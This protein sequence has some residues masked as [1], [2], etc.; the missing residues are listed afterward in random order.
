MNQARMG[1]L[2]AAALLAM[3][4]TA[5]AQ[6][7]G[8]AKAQ[9]GKKKDPG[10]AGGKDDKPKEVNLDEPA[11]DV[12][13]EGTEGPQGPDATPGG[14]GEGL[15]DICKI[16][17]TAC[18][19]IDMDKAAAREMKIDMYA[20]Q[21]IY[22]LR[23]HRFE[24]NPYFGLTM[25]DQFVGHNGPG[26]ALN[27]YITNTMAIGVNGN[28]YAGLN[29]NSAFNFET[30]RAGR[31]GEPVTEYQWNANANFTYVPAY[32][33]FAGFGDFIF[34][35]DIFVI[36]GVGAI[37][38]RPIAVVDP[39]NRS[40]SFKPKFNGRLGG[41]LRIFF[42]RWLS[43]VFEVS[44]YLFLDEL[45]NP[46]IA[47]GINAKTGKPKAQDQTTWLDPAGASFTNNVQAQVGLSI[48]L[49]FTWEYRLPK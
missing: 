27:W 44:D 25:N 46:K 3:P 16:D 13:K 11:A 10:K 34:H 32:G 33:K 17:P 41:G 5:M 40:F 9:A 42:N 14:E 2:V 19:T 48:F 28:F 47:E 6:P 36:G 4:V 29:S 39:D 7:R 26:L 1:L 8:A 37:S 35:Y 31:V 38:T 30:S 23:Y 43:A 12:P 49:P 21:Q 22:A 20:V 18:P 15:G 24:I 45:E